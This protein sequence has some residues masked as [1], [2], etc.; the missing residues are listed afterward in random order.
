MINSEIDKKG[1]DVATALEYL[2]LPTAKVFEL[3]ELSR[4]V[5]EK[6]VGNSVSICSIVNAKSG[7]CSEDCSFCP[8]SSFSES[9]IE[10]YDLLSTADIVKAAEKATAMGAHNMGIVT[11][12]KAVGLQSDKKAIV[13]AVENISAQLSLNGCAS[14]GTIDLAYMQELKAAGLSS[15]H[16]NLES[17]RS[18]YPTVCTTR[19]YD[20]NVAVIKNAQQAG[21]KVCSGA[22][23]GLGE[24]SAQRIELLADLRALDVDSIPLNFLNPVAGTKSAELYQVISPLEALKIIA[25]TRLMMPRKQIRIAGGREYTLRDMQS[26]IFAA[27]AN[28]LMIGDYLITGGRAYQDDLQM[29]EDAGMVIAENGGCGC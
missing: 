27:G 23:F 8:Q 16:H 4:R 7:N 18:F 15:L 14:L 25:V 12:G 2:N 17:S 20:D 26:W 1:I 29:I 10:E 6:Y 5:R 21:L 28:A 24:S 9:T 11:A 22:L 13:T 19:T 3:L